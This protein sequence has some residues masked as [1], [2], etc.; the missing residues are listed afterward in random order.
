MQYFLGPDTPW[1]QT[2]VKRVY[3]LKLDYTC[4]GFRHTSWDTK[5]LPSYQMF[6]WDFCTYT[7]WNLEHQVGLDLTESFSSLESE[8]HNLPCWAVTPTP[9]VRAKLC[10][11]PFEF[12]MHT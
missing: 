6:P 3:A 1:D 8:L 11:F 2:P 7:P 9:E 12:T 10:A 5:S 4:L